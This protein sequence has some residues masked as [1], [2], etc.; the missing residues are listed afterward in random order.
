M[1]EDIVV[2]AH[3]KNIRI[4]FERDCKH[5]KLAIAENE[6]LAEAARVAEHK[7]QKSTGKVS[8]R[9]DEANKYCELVYGQSYYDIFGYDSTDEKEIAE[10][11]VDLKRK[12][13]FE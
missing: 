3:D 10:N 13:G 9:I 1:T 4:I 12:T 8:S 2:S 6:R 7:K 5:C 11:I